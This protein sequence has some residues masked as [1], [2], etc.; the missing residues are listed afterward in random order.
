M[1]HVFSVPVILKFNDM[2]PASTIV[3]V[4]TSVLY[5]SCLT[6][7]SY[8]FPLSWVCGLLRA[9]T[10]LCRGIEA[11]DDGLLPLAVFD[12]RK[13]DVSCSATI[14]I[15]GSPLAIRCLTLFLNEFPN[16]NHRA[17]YPHEV[18]GK[19]ITYSGIARMIPHTQS[20]N[21]C[22]AVLPAILKATAVKTGALETR[23]W[24]TRVDH[25]EKLI[26][27]STLAVIR[28]TNLKTPSLWNSC[29]LTALHREEYRVI[30]SDAELVT[31]SKWNTNRNTDVRTKRH[32]GQTTI[33]DSAT[34]AVKGASPGA[35]TDRMSDVSWHSSSHSSSSHSS[36]YPSRSPSPVPASASTQARNTG[37]LSD[38]LK[39]RSCNFPPRKRLVRDNAFALWDGR[40]P[41][42]SGIVF[43]PF[44]EGG[45]QRSTCAPRGLTVKTSAQGFVSI[46]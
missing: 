5:P 32:P 2:T 35:V 45:F 43:G 26:F 46:W 28:E 4:S 8:S 36:P 38:H 23:F 39:L 1:S 11:C 15:K 40:V 12:I 20:K 16:W 37:P 44:V 6:G 41:C 10:K 27:L 33:I 31:W 21:V 17:C 18:L 34:P 19:T 22:S 42:L 24:W 7:E 30:H 13:D 3:P 25:V 29:V 9:I 14:R